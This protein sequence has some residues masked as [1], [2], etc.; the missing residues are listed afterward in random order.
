[1][2]FLITAGPTREPLDPVRYLS[3][4]SSGKMGYALAEAAQE[5]GHT[6]TLISGPV[7][8]R[9]PVGVKLY[10]V[11]TAQEMWETTRSVVSSAKVD[12]A[13]LAAAV[14]DYSPRFVESNKIKKSADTLTLELV[15]TPDILGSMRSAFGFTGFLTGFA[16]E[17]ENLVPNA[18]DKLKRKNCDLI[19][20]NDVSQEGTGFDS[21]ENEVVLCHRSGS[22][23]ALPRQS[24]RELATALVG[25]IMELAKEKLI[26]GS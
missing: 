14:A 20:A 26:A 25:M 13:I 5:G 15:R 2:H 6:V 3:N 4:R 8:L 23:E 10:K 16:A 24:K 18:H 19:I 7:A 17:T 11:E 12:V 21:D 9:T 22:T 1:M